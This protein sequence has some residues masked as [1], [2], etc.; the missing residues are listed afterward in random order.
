MSKALQRKI[1]EELDS[2]FKAIPGACFVDYSKITA[3]QFHAFR[4]H[5]REHELSCKVVKNRLLARTITLDLKD[6]LKG[7]ICAVYGDTEDK[8]VLSAKLVKDWIKENKVLKVKGA[9]INGEILTEEQYFKLMDIGTKEQVLSRLLSCIQMPM[10]NIARTINAV[11]EKLARVL[12]AYEKK[13][14]GGES[15]N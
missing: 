9:F 13:L 8:V 6:V 11:P 7:P 15:D 1:C 10:T 5:L 2:E 3:E 4:R 14:G 12:S